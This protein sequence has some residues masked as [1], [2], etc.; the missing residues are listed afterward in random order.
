MDHYLLDS[1]IPEIVRNG[2]GQQS[3][4]AIP[5]NNRVKGSSYFAAAVCQQDGVFTLSNSTMAA[6]SPARKAALND[7]L[8]PWNSGFNGEIGTPA[9]NFIRTLCCNLKLKNKEGGNWISNCH[10]LYSNQQK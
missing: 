7:A 1:P 5:A 6:I 2:I 8:S 4:D 3:L 10:L 9:L